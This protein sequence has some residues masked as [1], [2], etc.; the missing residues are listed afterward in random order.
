MVANQILVRRFDNGGILVL[1]M[2][3]NGPRQLVCAGPGGAD[4]CLLRRLNLLLSVFEE[5]LRGTLS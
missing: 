4:G 5:T 1:F 3:S 2:T